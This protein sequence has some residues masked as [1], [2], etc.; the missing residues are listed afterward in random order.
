MSKPIQEEFW[1]DMPEFVQ[2]KQTP[3]LELRVRFADQEALEEFSKL[4]GQKL[5]AKTKSIWHPELVRGLNGGKR[6]VE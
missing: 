4:I 2:E 6:Y 1:F 3:Y 5:T